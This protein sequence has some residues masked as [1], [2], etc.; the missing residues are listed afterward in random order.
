MSLFNSLFSVIVAS[1]LSFSDGG[2][3]WYPVE[4]TPMIEEPGSDVDSDVWVL[5]SKT[6][7]REK[8]PEKF[9]VR[10]PGDPLVRTLESGDLALRSEK[11]GEIFE[12]LISEWNPNQDPKAD[13]VYEEAGK[14][15]HEHVLHT[16]GH[17][18]TFRTYSD[19]MES[20]NYKDFVASFLIE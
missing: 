14:W 19:R 11:N 8:I 18:Y 16:E 13:A 6:I 10:L 17:V 12:L 20:P 3:G 1:V 9:M 2:D 4:K 5:F 7:D 15:V